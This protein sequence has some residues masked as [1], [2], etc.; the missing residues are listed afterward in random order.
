MPTVRF[1]GTIHPTFLQLTSPSFG[2][3]WPADDLGFPLPMEA[4]VQGS[5]F[6]VTCELPKYEEAMG[7]VLLARAGNLIRVFTNAV[8]FSMAIG[9]TITFDSF[10]APDGRIGPVQ[11]ITFGLVGICSAFTF[12]P[13]SSSENAEF[14]RA[15]NTII[16]EPNLAGS[17]T[18]L[19]ETLVHWHQTPTNCGRVLDSLRKAVAPAVK[20][21]KGW[22]ILQGIVNADDA[23]MKFV[24]D[25]STD[26]RHG[27]RTAGT[28]SRDVA[29]TMRRTWEVMN[30]FIEYR[31]RG[32]QPLSLTEFPMLRG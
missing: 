16:T 29:E 5:K 22:A 14:H 28:S 30:R 13:K 4:S 17:M 6:T 24:S 8:S 27:D 23:Y 7:A 15:L 18:D 31:K 1:Y 20:P 19:A 25:I 9:L 26:P 11:H 2:T 32:S 3:T 12:P 10:Q 21:I